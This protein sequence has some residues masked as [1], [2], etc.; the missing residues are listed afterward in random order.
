MATFTKI[1]DW[2]ENLHNAPDIDMNADTIQMKLTNTAFA[3][4]T[5]NPTT[6]TNGIA[7][8]ATDIVYTNYSD[9]MTVDRVL[10]GITSGQTAGVYKFDANDI[11]ITA[12][13]G[14][15]P[16]FQFVYLFNQTAATPVDPLIGAWDHG[17]VI[18]L[19]VGE[20]ATVTWNAGG[21]YTVT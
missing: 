12:V 7:A 11:V 19:A 13:T 14:T 3:S 5:P 10:E 9:D 15:L 1:N 17:S 2:M 21:I 20:A 18:S 6:D 8:N 16:D 4:E